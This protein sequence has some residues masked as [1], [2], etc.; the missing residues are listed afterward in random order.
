MN[1]M[2][3]TLINIYKK[4]FTM[5]YIKAILFLVS[6]TM[7][8]IFISC[9]NATTPPTPT[10]SVRDYTWT[11]DTLNIPD[12]FQNLMSS[13]YAANS[14]DIYLVGHNSGSQIYA[15]DGKM[16][17]YNGKD[18]SVVRLRDQLG[19]FQLKAIHGSSS[20]NVWAVGSRQSSGDDFPTSFIAQYN[21]VSW[22]E[23]L[24]KSPNGIY[25]EPLSKSDVY[26]VYVESET[27]VWACG[28][29]GVVYHYDGTS[30]DVDTIRI[31]LNEDENFI[32][33]DIVI[34]NS[35]I[36]LLGFKNFQGAFFGT[37]YMFKKENQDWIIQ[38]SIVQ[39][40]QGIKNWK[41][42]AGYFYLSNSNQLY[43]MGL[44]GVFKL[45]GHSWTNIFEN[46]SSIE[47]ISEKDENNILA[48]GDFGLVFHYN[49]SD[50]KKLSNLEI[51][52]K[53][54]CVWQDSDEAIIVGQLLGAYPMKTIVL[55]GK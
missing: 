38:D 41:W 27:E 50:W 13:M 14:E 16:W 9:E 39:D 42:G 23:H 6:F 5:Q 28:E 46:D 30:W 10:K 19:G 51:A 34:Y 2:L 33:K 18:W 52:D 25:D 48:V 53:Y 54:T 55:H 37:Y 22:K 4:S 29:G 43:T 26:S 45:E 35:E 49:D 20:N 24:R 1:N 47:G 3:T 11:I 8:L 12:A 21:G 36:L 17:H 44:G 7:A 31:E 32:A 40:A 15:G